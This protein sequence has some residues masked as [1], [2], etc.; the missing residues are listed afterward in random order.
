MLGLGGER[1]AKAELT[2]STNIKIPITAYN[3]TAI[4]YDKHILYIYIYIYI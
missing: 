2:N 4:R 3:N 1:G